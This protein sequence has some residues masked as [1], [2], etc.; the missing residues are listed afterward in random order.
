[1][2]LFN[3]Y[4]FLIA[5][6][7]L[8]S[9]QIPLQA[10][11]SFLDEDDL[12]SSYETISMSSESDF[13]EDPFA[14][15]QTSSEIILGIL[16][17][18]SIKKL[19]LASLVCSYWKKLSV[20]QH[21]FPLFEDEKAKSEFFTKEKPLRISRVIFKDPKLIVNL[22]EYA[23]FPD[24][25]HLLWVDHDV[26]EKFWQFSSSK[27]LRFN[28]HLEMP[29]KTVQNWLPCGK[30]LFIFYPLDKQMLLKNAFQTLRIFIE[31]EPHLKDMR[32]KDLNLLKIF[33]LSTATEDR[34]MLR[35]ACQKHI[36]L[37]PSLVE[38]HPVRIW[39]EQVEI[40]WQL[41]DNFKASAQLQEETTT[42]IATQ[43]QPR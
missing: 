32:L 18:L 26:Q 42:V 1:M 4:I 27:T 3:F 36:Q 12:T 37:R 30:I 19:T 11:D 38:P 10:S 5:N 35:I 20:H 6:I 25:Y 23:L 40:Q 2:K 16:D 8:A 24:F 17:N 39:L 9:F 14:I 13:E 21:L 28:R 31:S 7:A 43:A 29:Y 15:F 34:Q 22:H 33:T 41:M